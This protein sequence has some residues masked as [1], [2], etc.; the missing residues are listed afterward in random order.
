MRQKSKINTYIP[1][2]R[3][4]IRTQPHTTKDLCMLLPHFKSWMLCLL[5]LNFSLACGSPMWVQILKLCC[6][7]FYL[8]FIKMLSYCIY[9]SATTFIQYTC[10]IHSCW[11]AWLT[12]IFTAIISLLF[13]CTQLY[14][15]TVLLTDF[16]IGPNVLLLH[17]SALDLQGFISAGS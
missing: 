14:L 10:S 13:D 16:F 15:T 3:L 5:L 1:K 7:V 12:F 4:R 6:S 11:Y 8:S 2:H 9:Y 17:G